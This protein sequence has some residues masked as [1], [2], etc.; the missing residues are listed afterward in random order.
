MLLRKWDYPSQ[1]SRKEYVD[2]PYNAWVAY[3]DLLGFKEKLKTSPM[4]IIQDELDEIVQDLRALAKEFEENLAYLFYADTFIFYSKSDENKHYPGLLL[5]ATY[6]MEKCIYKGT[7][8]RGAI[9]FGEIA[10]GHDSRIMMGGAFLES[11]RYG[12]DQNWLGLILTPKASDQLQKMNLDPRRHGFI[13]GEI[14]WKK[15][16][17]SSGEVHAYSFCRGESNFPC[18][19]LPKLREMQHFSPRDRDKEKY[20]KTIEF[21]EKHWKR[22]QY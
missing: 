9:S 10:V 18:P 1:L 21:L 3:F 8:L 16:A 2:H 5:A 17:E 12:E 22:I 11:H 14:P 19:L 4:F 13:Y 6:F 20:K 15:C 7:A